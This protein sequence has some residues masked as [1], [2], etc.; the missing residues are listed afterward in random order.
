MARR[1]MEGLGMNSNAGACCDGD[2]VL[3]PLVAKVG[4]ERRGFGTRGA[5]GGGCGWKAGSGVEGGECEVLRK[6]RP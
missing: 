6:G 1:R 4:G 2:S 3:A 5:G